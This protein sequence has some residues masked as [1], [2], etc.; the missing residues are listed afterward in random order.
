[1]NTPARIALEECAP[2]G[3]IEQWI[4]ARG[5]SA[6]N[7]ALLFLHGG[8]AEAQS[9]FLHL[10]APWEERFTVINWDQRGSGKTYGRNPGPIEDINIERMT[11]DA[12]EVAEHARALLGKDKLILVGH[13]WGTLLGW[14]AV[15][16]RPE[17]FHAFVAAGMLVSW[18]RMLPIHEAHAR[19]QAEA[20]GDAAAIAALD[21]VRNLPLDDFARALPTRRFLMSPADVDYV[22]NVQ[23]AFLGNGPPFPDTGDVHDWVQGGETTR[24]APRILPSFLQYDAYALGL[25]ADI[26]VAVIQGRD[27]MVT[28]VEPVRQFVEELSAPAKS[29][30]LIDG[31]HFACFTNPG[32]FVAALLEYVRP[33]AV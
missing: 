9:P 16:A 24:T 11:Q 5:A 30:T 17:L 32:G 4:S 29:F 18:T 33:F 7:P 25:K 6:D 27:D 15:K 31:G 10:F 26:P 3:G 28:P 20:A 1:M 22:R 2:V 21:A 23:G 12:I 19:V 13:S 14:R 8:P